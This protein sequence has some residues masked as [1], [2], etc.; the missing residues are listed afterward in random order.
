MKDAYQIDLIVCNNKREFNKY[1]RTY[2]GKNSVTIDYI[3][4]TNKLIKSNFHE[5]APHPIVIGVAI[6]TA[7]TNVFNKTDYGVQRD[8]QGG[9]ERC[10]QGP[11]HQVRQD[12]VDAQGLVEPLRS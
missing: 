7:F 11:G 2:G 8:H 9:L 5:S 12:G 1:S 10:H 4:I 6:K 3:T